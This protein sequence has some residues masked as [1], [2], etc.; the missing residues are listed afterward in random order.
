MAIKPIE[1]TVRTHDGAAGIDLKEGVYAG[2]LL[3]LIHI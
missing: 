1:A 3:S 2:L